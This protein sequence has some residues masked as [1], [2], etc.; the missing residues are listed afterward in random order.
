MAPIH[1]FLPGA[2][3]SNWLVA[4]GFTAVGAAMWLR[5][6]VLESSVIGLECEAGLASAQCLVRKVATGIYQ[7]YGF[8]FAALALAVL[9]LVRPTVLLFGLGIAVAGW[10]LVLYNASLSGIAAALLI[11]SL[12]RAVPRQDLPPG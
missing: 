7:H 4:A 11:L 5:Y 6:M 12:A 2:R 10:G 9:N 8:G 3:A 1:T